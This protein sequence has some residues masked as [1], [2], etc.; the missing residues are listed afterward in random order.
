LLLCSRFDGSYNQT[1]SNRRFDNSYNQ[2]ETNRS[3][4]DGF[5]PSNY[6][7]YPTS[8]FH[9][10]FSDDR[11]RQQQNRNQ[12]HLG[13]F[14]QSYDNKTPAPGYND[15]YSSSTA[16]YFQE[17]NC[18][19]YFPVS[20]SSAPFA[21]PNKWSQSKLHSEVSAVNRPT[22]WARSDNSARSSSYPGVV[23]VRQSKETATSAALRSQRSSGYTSNYSNNISPLKRKKNFS[24]KDKDG[25]GNFKSFPTFGKK[26]FQ[27]SLS[28]VHKPE[29]SQNKVSQTKGLVSCIKKEMEEGEEGEVQE[30]PDQIEGKENLAAHKQYAVSVDE[31]N[32]EK[33]DSVNVSNVVETD[34]ITHIRGNFIFVSANELLYFFL[35]R[36]NRFV[37]GTAMSFND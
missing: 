5:Q 12:D 36:S 15:V 19:E 22:R 18:D 17:E 4:S 30:F 26:V 32:M 34:E 16:S 1:D 31:G 7:L 14:S 9:Q 11:E 10:S 23:D 24:W 28:V 13:R 35:C 37:D 8:G 2:V 29:N 21:T 27:K 25:P 20:S 3:Y 33:T 6:A